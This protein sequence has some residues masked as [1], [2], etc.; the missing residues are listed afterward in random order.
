LLRE[1]KPERRH[2]TGFRRQIEIDFSADPIPEP[3]EKAD[4]H[5]DAFCC[6][7]SCLG[8]WPD[9]SALP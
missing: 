2:R 5:G 6:A 8:A 4:L 1:V 3:A 7:R 9:R